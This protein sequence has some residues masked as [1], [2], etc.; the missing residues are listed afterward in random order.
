MIDCPLCGGKGKLPDR[1]VHFGDGVYEPET[2]T[3]C[4]GSG[5]VEIEPEK[6]NKITITKSHGVWGDRKII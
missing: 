6:H 5:E 3:F 4:R 2:C 1:Q